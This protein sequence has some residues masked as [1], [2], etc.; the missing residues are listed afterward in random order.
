MRIATLLTLLALTLPLAAVPGAAA[1]EVPPPPTPEWGDLGTLPAPT[2]AAARA[3]LADD[4]RLADV[5]LE[6]EEVRHGQALHHVRFVQTVEELPV[7]GTRVQLSLDDAGTVRWRVVDVRPDVAASPCPDARDAAVD[8]ARE[9][10]PGE[11]WVPPRAEHLVTL[12]GET[13]WRVNLLPRE[14]LG[15]WMVDVACDGS[16]QQVQDVARYVGAEATGTVFPVSPIVAAEDPDLRDN[17]AGVGALGYTDLKVEV[18][19]KGLDGGGFLSGEYAY[20]VTPH[21][22]EVDGVYDYDRG[23]PRFEEVQAYHYTDWAQ[24]HLQDLGFDDIH[25]RTTATVPRVPGAY[26]AFYTGN[27]DAE[28]FYG[29]HG[30]PATLLYGPEHIEPGAGGLADAAEDAHVIWHEYGHAVL[31]DQ[32]GICCTDEAAAMHEAFGDWQATTFSTRFHALQEVDGCMAPWFGSYLHPVANGSWPCYRDIANDRTMEDW[33][34][35]DDPHFNQLIWSGGLW[36]ME[37]ELMAEL[38]REE[39]AAAFERVLYEANFLLP[40][41]ATFA[42]ASLAILQADAALTNGTHH[43]VLAEEIVHRGFLAEEDVPMVEELGGEAQDTVDRV[44]PSGG[45]DAN[46]GVP[47]PGAALA[48]GAVVVAGLLALKRP[49]R[50]R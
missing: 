3:H 11:L 41:R 29:Y 6:L 46:V 36:A 26:T 20:M 30:V 9:E 42:A 39:G 50:P 43:Q 40:E 18:T 33:K 28:I 13:V 22:Y 8:A 21:A 16:V 7:E 45:G 37:T 19:L 48:L 5:T 32:A 14:P 38:G 35:G 2:E 24:R 44:T 49:R 17:P 47:G 31:D 27:P 4:P 25:N 10:L 34:E 23:D 12:E 1:G 15:S